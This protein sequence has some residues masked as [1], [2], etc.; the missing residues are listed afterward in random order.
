M[1]ACRR[2][3]ALL[4]AALLLTAPPLAVSAEQ[5]TLDFSMD[6]LDGELH[7]LTAYRGRWVVVN[8]WAT[9]CPPCVEEIPEL[10]AFQAANPQHQVLGINFEDIDPEAVRAFAT[11]HG[12][13]YPVLPT[14][15]Q[16]PAFTRLRGLPTTQIVNPAGKLVA[17]HVG[18]VTRQMLEDFI[19]EEEAAAA[20]Q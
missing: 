4:C 16:P 11:E 20:S 15:P 3:A 19:R 8:Y 14:G 6:D 2:I 7:Q 17:D 1:T 9:W 13:N 10:V 5:T 18:T 12:I